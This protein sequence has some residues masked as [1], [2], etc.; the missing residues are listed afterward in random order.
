M[1]QRIVIELGSEEAASSLARALGPLFGE[2]NLEGTVVI[3]SGEASAERFASDV[4]DAVKAWL[5]ASDVDS[6]QVLLEGR[7]YTLESSHGPEVPA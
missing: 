2:A 7:T 3:L 1:G 6:V 4:L 5:D